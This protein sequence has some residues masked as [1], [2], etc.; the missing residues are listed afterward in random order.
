MDPQSQSFTPFSSNSTG[1]SGGGETSWRQQSDIV[2]VQQVQAE[3]AERIAR[4]ERRQDEDARLKSVWGQSSPFPSVL[5]GTPQQAPLQHLPSDQFRS[6]DDDANNLMSSLHLD[7]EEEPR[8]GLGATSRANSV[9]F[10]ETANQN[11]FSHSSRPSVEFFSRTS[12]G[13]SGL[14]MTERSSSHKSEGRAS[15]A[16]SMRSAASGR[17]NSLNLETAYGSG[18]STRSPAEAPGLAPGLLLLG[19]APAI[20]RCWMNTNFK[21]DAL[22]YAAVCTGSYK[23]FLDLRLIHKLGFEAS[24]RAKADGVRTVELPIYFP[25]AVSHPASS[26]SSSPA[27]QLPSLQIEFRVIER[28]DPEEHCKAIQIFIGSDVLRAH[29]ADIL[30]SSNSMTLYDNERNKL[31]IPLSRPESEAAFNG[32]YV[33]SGEAQSAQPLSKIDEPLKEQIYLNGLG[34]GSSA[35]SVSS[36][37]ASPPPGKYRPPGALAAESSSIDSTKLGVIGSS[38]NDT[39]PA[40]RQSTISRPSLSH[41][42]TRGELEADTGAQIAP[43]RSGSTSGIWGGS[44]RREGTTSAST[45]ATPSSSTLDWAG[46]SKNREASPYQR[47][48]PGIKVLKPKVSART[49]SSAATSS[50]GIGASPADPMKSRFFDEGRRRSVENG[51]GAKT[52]TAGAKEGSITGTPITSPASAPKSKANPIGGASAFSWLAK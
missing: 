11:H 50:A 26:R 45:A 6:F 31:S 33:T 30:F 29:N 7:A 47:K 12:S 42:N 15:S 36:A 14:Q 22:L 5:S 49:V 16:H 52:P 19:A 40:S 10:D 44:W 35:A 17:A 34:V 51:A 9:R 38:D 43:S 39:R 20:I 4:L 3:H 41:L 48:D 21:H 24:I 13:Y 1:N 37:A 28:T 25:E 18:D 2:R 32:L 46:A 23:S 27:P 8:R